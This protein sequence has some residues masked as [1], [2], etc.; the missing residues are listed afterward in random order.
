[1]AELVSCEH[2][3]HGRVDRALGKSSG[4]SGSS[5]GAASIPPCVL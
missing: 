5:L 3:E 2:G 4:V 1:M